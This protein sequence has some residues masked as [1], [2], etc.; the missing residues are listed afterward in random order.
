MK[1]KKLQILILFIFFV[2]NLCICSFAGFYF[3]PQNHTTINSDI[4]NNLFINSENNTSRGTLNFYQLFKIFSTDDSLSAINNSIA[5]QDAS[6]WANSQLGTP[7]Y[8]VKAYQ[9]K[10]W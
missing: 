10:Y 2:L 9:I 7:Q 4:S 1:L 6:Q 5:G 3:N 8:P